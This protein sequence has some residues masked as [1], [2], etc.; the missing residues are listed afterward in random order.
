HSL[1]RTQAFRDGVHD[2]GTTVLKEGFQEFLNPEYTPQLLAKLVEDA[3]SE[4]AVRDMLAAAPPEVR[5]VIETK[6][7][8]IL[9]HPDM[10]EKLRQMIL[11]NL[12]AIDTAAS[13]R[14]AQRQA[15]EDDRNLDKRV[16]DLGEITWSIETYKAHALILGDIGPLV[17]DDESG[18]WGRIFHGMPQMIW[19][20][21]SNHSL[22]IGKASGSATR[23]D[24]EEVNL[25]SAENSIEFFVASQRTQREDEYQR[26]IGSRID[27]T[28]SE[29]LSELKR[30]V[31]EY[32]TTPG[33]AL[34]TES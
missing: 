30:T 25:A 22:L 4:P 11:P 18:E 19:F 33:G 10:H 34:T 26:R 32:L 21:L 20:P 12:N 24:F 29:Q 8:E 5:P 23:P 6:M 3:M 14:S 27:R 7:R 31:R 17:R 1:I 13:A 16:R 2:I 15:L 9:L 28:T